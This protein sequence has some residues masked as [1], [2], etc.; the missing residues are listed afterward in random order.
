M[1]PTRYAR[2]AAQ[3]ALARASSELS[4][5]STPRAET[6]GGLSKC[7]G[8]SGS[9]TLNRMQCQAPR[10]SI[11]ASRNAR[12]RRMLALPAPASAPD[13]TGPSPTPGR[14]G[15]GGRAGGAGSWSVLRR[16]SSEAAPVLAAARSSALSRLGGGSTRCVSVSLSSCTSIAWPAASVTPNACSIVSLGFARRRARNSGSRPALRMTAPVT[17]MG[18]VMAWSR[19][20]GAPPAVTHAATLT[21]PERSAGPRGRITRPAS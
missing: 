13:V 6:K 9:A 8:M 5:A 21:A 12:A 15:A 1:V 11:V 20:R 3:M 16:N 19:V 4:S 7:L 18:F 14:S 2:V 17:S 10:S